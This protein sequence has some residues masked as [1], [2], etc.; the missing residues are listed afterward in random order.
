MRTWRI[1]TKV[2]KREFLTFQNLP[3]IA[4]VDTGV[5]CDQFR[6]FLLQINQNKVKG[7]VTKL[8]K[9][10]VFRSMRVYMCVCLRVCVCVFERVRFVFHNSQDSDILS[11]KDFFL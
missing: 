5:L 6:F 7:T 9:K 10:T 11:D 4:H 1:L 2:I 8:I 3:Y